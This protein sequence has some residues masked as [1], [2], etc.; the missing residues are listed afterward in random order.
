[1]NQ[2]FKPDVLA[3]AV[4]SPE[5]LKLAKQHGKKFEHIDN[6]NTVTGYVFQDSVYVT[7]IE[8]INQ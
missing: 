8:I 2:F 3:K 7:G 5:Q 4:A 6:G 1:M